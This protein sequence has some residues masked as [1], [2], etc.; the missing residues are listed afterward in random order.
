MVV[1]TFMNWDKYY[2]YQF[3][4]AIILIA[5]FRIKDDFYSMQYKFGVLFMAVTGQGDATNIKKGSETESK[6]YR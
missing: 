2:V 4:S 6:L 5:F 1:S 3:N